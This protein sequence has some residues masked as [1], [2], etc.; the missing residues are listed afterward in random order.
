MTVLRIVPNVACAD[1]AQ[2]RAFYETIFG[3]PVVMDLG[4]ILTFG[5][6]APTT[7]Q[8]SLAREGGAG[9]PVPDLS[10]EVDDVD[11][12]HRRAVAAGC[13][14]L[15]DLVDEP[16]GVR[17]FSVRDPCGKIVNVLAHRAMERPTT[18]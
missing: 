16:W 4:W 9:A 17:R 18:P 7:P 8:L 15:R 10:V 14:I 11:S 13:E 1:P 6:D 3:L 2:A 5:A 12:V